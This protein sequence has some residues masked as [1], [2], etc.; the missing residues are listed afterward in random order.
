VSTVHVAN[1]DGT[2][3]FREVYSGDMGGTLFRRHG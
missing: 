2:A 1:R 3:S